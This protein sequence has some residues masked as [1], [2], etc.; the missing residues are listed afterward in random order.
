MEIIF[1]LC[2]IIHQLEA[3]ELSCSRKIPL[4]SKEKLR[5]VHGQKHRLFYLI[6]NRF[7]F[8]ARLSVFFYFE[9]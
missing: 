3:E 7:V 2:S 9:A 4:A 5:M 1:I 6:D 8:L